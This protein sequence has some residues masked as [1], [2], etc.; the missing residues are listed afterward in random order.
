MEVPRSLFVPWHAKTIWKVIFS[1]IPSSEPEGSLPMSFD[2]EW[3]VEFSDSD[4]Q[5]V[6]SFLVVELDDF[7]YST[8][9]IGGI[10]VKNDFFGGRVDGNLM[11]LSA[12]SDED[13]YLCH[14]RMLDDGSIEGEIWSAGGQHETWTATKKTIE[15]EP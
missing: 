1:A 6:A 5:F 9:S 13:V 11:R 7:V 15:D 4:D 3:S 10:G 2:G 14:I 12:V 8:G